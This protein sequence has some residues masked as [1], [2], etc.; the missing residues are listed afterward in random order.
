M[1]LASRAAA[2]LTS[3]FK[4]KMPATPAEIVGK[5]REAKARVTDLERQHSA[6]CLAWADTNDP[7]ERDRLGAEV[8]AARVNLASLELALKA[9][10]NRTAAEERA[11]L[12]S[13]NASRV[14][15]MTMHLRTAEKAA[16]ELVDA[17]EKAGDARRKL[18]AAS[19]KARV[20]AP[21]PLPAGSLTERGMLDR[22]IANEM[23]RVSH[24]AKIGALPG[25]KP[26]SL[27]T[28]D[29]PNSIVPLAEQMKQAHNFAIRVV[30]GE[31]ADPRT[32]TLPVGDSVAPLADLPQRAE[33][34]TIAEPMEVD[35]SSVGP[36]VP[37]DTSPRKLSISDDD[38]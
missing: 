29:D 10:H 34:S 17:L 32:P 27:S 1:S 15:S 21:S 36:F 19:A 28:K 25:G 37:P 31:L 38:R 11:R 8:A 7:S 24:T 5:V 23:Y 14:H 3:G 20:S 6:A 16:A 35:W 33:Q 4:P 12:A 22:I 26:S 2:A 13:L 18:L 9:A 30:R